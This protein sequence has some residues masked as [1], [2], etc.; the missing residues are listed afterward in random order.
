M[1]A[2][3]IIVPVYNAEKYIE[4][5]VESILAQSFKDFELILVDD[6]SSDN[7][8]EICDR[9]Q[10]KDT[11]V[12]VIH[13]KNKGVSGA[14]NAGLDISKGDYIA[15]VDSDDFLDGE[16][17]EKLFDGLLK[18]N[19]D[20]AVCGFKRVSSE[21]AFYNIDRSNN[22][23]EYQEY[24]FS[25]EECVKS[26]FSLN[27][28]VD[29]AAW[30][31]LYKKS[32]FENVRY[33][34]GRIYEDTYLIMDII[35]KCNTVY[36][37]TEELYNYRNTPGSITNT[38][39][40]RDK[41]YLFS[42]NRVCSIYYNFYPQY[43]NQV[44]AQKCKFEFV[45]LGKIFLSSKPEELKYKSELISILNKK[46]RFVLSRPEVSITRK[47]SAIALR[48]HPHLF[49]V[50]IYLKKKYFKSEI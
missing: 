45:V 18:S 43:L 1:P 26:L 4:D 2:L 21:E 17:Y 29:V 22:V 23:A 15:F 12:R 38:V 30:N 39:D 3:T 47:I 14:R 7:S 10:R 48:I 35:L 31:K 8:G 11:R 6:E 36:I 28:I 49:K 13:Q 16:I 46:I 44:E 32:I 33:P 41:D 9:Y 24:V 42:L 5:C 20:M 19:A 40:K 37:T 27:D 25:K 34:E 50:C